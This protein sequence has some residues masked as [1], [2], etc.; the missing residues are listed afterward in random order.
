MTWSIRRFPLQYH[1]LV[2]SKNNSYFLGIG[3]IRD[4]R[5]TCIFRP[6]CFPLCVVS[7]IGL[8]TIR[9]F[10]NTH[11]FSNVVIMTLNYLLCHISVQNLE[12]FTFCRYIY[13]LPASTHSN[14]QRH[15][16]TTLPLYHLHTSNIERRSLIGS[17]LIVVK[18]IA[19]LI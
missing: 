14:K 7:K 10:F 4:I 19:T 1:S 12:N 16:L 18:E 8:S 9:Y 15:Y 13:I 11:M 17:F 3:P 5:F 2:H 6:I